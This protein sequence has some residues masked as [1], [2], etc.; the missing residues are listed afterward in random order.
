M[1]DLPDSA[2]YTTATTTPI[3]VTAKPATVAPMMVGVLLCLASV[4]IVVDARPVLGTAVVVEATDD[5]ASV[6]AVEGVEV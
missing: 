1:M 6:G 4:V 3:A 2:E 5:A